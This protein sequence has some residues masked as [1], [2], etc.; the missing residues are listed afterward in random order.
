LI[1][2]NEEFI[3]SPS[4]H[5][6]SGESIP[7][8]MHSV[9]AA[10]LPATAAAIYFFGFKAIAL[11]VTCI[12]A[13][14]A[15]EYVFQ[16]V[17]KK[18]I[19]IWDGSVII[20]GLLLALTLPPTLP[21]FMAVLGSIAAVALGKQIFGGLGQN[22]FN[23]ALVGRAFL[24]AAFPV[25]MTTWALPVS[26][27]G[28]A[29][30]AV[31]AATPLNLMK[32]EHQT[33]AFTKLFLGN[34]GGSLGETSA[35]AL[36]LGAAY[37]YYKGYIEWRIPT[38][39]IGTVVVFSGVFWLTNPAKY[40]DPLFMVFSGGLIIGAFYMA[41]DYATSPITPAGKL[42]FGVS[43]GV[44]IVIIR[45]MG[46]LPEGVMYAILLGNMV[47]PI[48]NRFTKPRIYGGHAGPNL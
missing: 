23:P 3:I 4:P 42:Y 19:T 17:R 10:L 43:I 38:S 27:T 40:P 33:T 32:F 9:V 6:R 47:T 11:I 16:S 31:N 14:L 29:V 45:L 28:K 7:K 26:W 21:V 8:I 35:L 44:V 15:T 34:I 37:L 22:I 20:T 12:A 25:A 5:V 18:P 30:D 46:G 2:P 39:V 1:E 13:S 41:T 36:L 24:Q 48:I